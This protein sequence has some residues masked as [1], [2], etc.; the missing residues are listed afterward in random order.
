MRP[1][2]GQRIDCQRESDKLLTIR[3]PEGSSKY[4]QAHPVTYHVQLPPEYD[5]YRRYPTVVTLHGTGSTPQQ[6]I[7]WWAGG[8]AT[9]GTR[10]GQATRQGYIVIAP[11]WAHEQQKTY[12]Y[13]GEEHAAVLYALRDACRR[14]SVDTDRRLSLRPFRLAE[15]QLGTSA[16]RI[17]TFGPA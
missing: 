15:M 7:D 10:L 1:P 17:P 9:N 2:Q 6:Q 11:A 16:C 12:N 5:S 3:S 14:F 4:G 13:T 8:V